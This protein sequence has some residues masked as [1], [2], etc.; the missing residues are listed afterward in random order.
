MNQAMACDC[1]WFLVFHH[2]SGWWRRGGAPRHA[3]ERLGKMWQTE[4][5]GASGR[6]DSHVKLR[7]Y[8]FNSF[9]DINKHPPYLIRTGAGTFC[10]DNSLLLLVVYFLEKNVENYKVYKV[11]KKWKIWIWLQRSIKWHNRVVLKIEDRM[12][13]LSNPLFLLL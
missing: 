6:N 8:N 1:T 2:F 13:P 9:W 7:T 11:E 12:T 3:A 4:K 10:F 5:W